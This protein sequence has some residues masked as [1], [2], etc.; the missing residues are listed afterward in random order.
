[1][2]VSVCESV[3]VGVAV[4]VGVSECEHELGVKE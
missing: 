2:I 1:M 4:G 3:K